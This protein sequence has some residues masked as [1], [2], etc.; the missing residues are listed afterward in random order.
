MFNLVKHAGHSIN[1]EL[2][3]DNLD[4]YCYTCHDTHKAEKIGSFL[5][6]QEKEGK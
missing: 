4:V 5:L 1:L 6:D 2:N 3:G